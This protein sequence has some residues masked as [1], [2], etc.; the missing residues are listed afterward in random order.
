M[1]ANYLN[2]RRNDLQS[3]IN[4]MHLNHFMLL[5]K[6]EE[7]VGD[8]RD[9]KNEGGDYENLE[10]YISLKREEARLIESMGFLTDEMRRL[11]RQ[12]DNDIDRRNVNRNV[13]RN[14]NRGNLPNIDLN[15]ED[16]Y[17]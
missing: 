10:E 6:L 15:P 11:Q 5:N 17:F 9:I 1:N 12:L 16:Y 8:I 4:D 14:E 13:N 7:V 3:V 2:N